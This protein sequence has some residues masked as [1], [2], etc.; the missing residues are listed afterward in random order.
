M[1][2]DT[3][4]NVFSIIENFARTIESAFLKAREIV[5][6]NELQQSPPC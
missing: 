6:V 3:L 1:L 4:S 2:F 5:C